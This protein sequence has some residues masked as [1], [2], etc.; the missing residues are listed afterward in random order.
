MAS[1]TEVDIGTLIV[2]TEGVV[3]GSPRIAG[4]R[5]SVKHIAEDYNEGLTV[6]QMLELYPTI[7]A[8]G[9][10]AAIAYYLANKAAVD[11]DIEDEERF[12]EEWRRKYPNGH[13]PGVEPV[14]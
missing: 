10:H 12:V 4:T 8:M 14:E 13:G 9:A 3:G 2:S 11:Q 1:A 7:D 5:I 6:Q